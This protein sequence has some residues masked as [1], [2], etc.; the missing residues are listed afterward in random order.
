MFYRGDRGD[1]GDSPLVARLSAVTR[2]ALVGV[3]GVTNWPTV[4]RVTYCILAGVT[5]T[6]PVFYWRVTCVTLVTLTKQLNALQ[7]RLEP[8]RVDNIQAGAAAVGQSLHC[9]LL[10]SI[11]PCDSSSTI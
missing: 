5:A 4:T 11:A 3:T 8:A 6:G 1:I 10:A 2:G 7:F 9:L